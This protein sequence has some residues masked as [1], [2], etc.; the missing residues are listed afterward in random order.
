MQVVCQ[1]CQYAGDVTL[2]AS[3]EFICPGCGSA[4]RTQ[5]EATTAWKPNEGKRRLGKF[6][7]ISPV[8]AGGFGTVYAARDTELD[9]IVAIKVPRGD[10]LGGMPGDT[11]RF[12]REARSAAQLRHP[13]I[14]SIYEVG[15]HEGV[16]FLVE[17]FVRGITLTDLLSG[18]RVAQQRA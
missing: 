4:I 17:D 11:D 2:S 12:L 16:S 8:G 14:V 5:G 13:S 1:Q 18:E 3:R 9:G 7:L 10:G 6:E 15:Q